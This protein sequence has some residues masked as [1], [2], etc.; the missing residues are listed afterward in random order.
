MGHFSQPRLVRPRRR[1]ATRS[2]VRQRARQ[3]RDRY[4]LDAGLDQL[5]LAFLNE[6]LCSIEEE[7]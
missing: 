1:P 5:H 7:L 3:F 6:E 4:A 2:Q